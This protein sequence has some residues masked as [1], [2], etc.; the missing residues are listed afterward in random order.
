MAFMANNY[1]QDSDITNAYQNLPLND[2]THLRGQGNSNEKSQQTTKINVSGD[3]G[4]LGYTEVPP[5]TSSLLDG[6]FH[7]DSNY[8]SK[9]RWI[10]FWKWELLAGVLSICAMIAVIGLLSAIENRPLTS[11]R[12]FLQP[13]TLLS[14]LATVTNSALLFLVAEC[15]GQSKWLYFQLR[16]QRLSNYETFDRATRGPLGALGLMW[17]LKGRVMTA[18]IGAAITVGALLINPFVQQVISFPKRTVQ[19]EG[20]DFASVNVS[21]VYDTG[22]TY[23]GPGAEFFS[24]GVDP[25]DNAME[26]AIAGGL[27]SPSTS[28]MSFCSGSRCSWPTFTTLGICSSCRDVTQTT[29]INCTEDFATQCFYNTPSNFTLGSYFATQSG[30]LSRTLFNSSAVAPGYGEYLA[31]GSPGLV[32]FA[33]IKFPEY[34][35]RPVP[36]PEVLECELHLCA[37]TAANYSYNVGAFPVADAFIEF[38]LATTSDI[39]NNFTGPNNTA[40]PYGNYQVNQTN[41]KTPYTGNTNFTINLEDLAAISQF[42]VNFF[43]TGSP[44][45]T[46]TGATLANNYL[47]KSSNIPNSI[48]A[49][50]LSMTNV[51]RNGQNH[52]IVP[53]SSYNSE[54]YIRVRWEWLILPALSII[55]ANVLLVLTV[56]RNT[57]RNVPL[58]KSSSL[59]LL[60]Q[61]VDIQE[62]DGREQSIHRMKKS[63]ENVL[64]QLEEDGRRRIKV[65]QDANSLVR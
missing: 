34:T 12:F 44:A 23:V 45:A 19:Y 47:Y 55:S 3:T 43:T 46:N 22:L 21:K 16:P 58:W 33:T 50:A 7:R 29:A 38:P 42:L 62:V 36:Q 54:T 4:Y 5:H 27:S 64:V 63:A 26:G 59:P 25:I 17:M 10:L 8:K 15:I 51:I 13:N 1:H 2:T 35:A 49:M 24:Y 18:T 6:D 20:Q 57:R 53:G 52:T 56:Y 40:H 65:V 30:R 9:I 14:I 60:C 32:S 28:T 41:L 31:S 11:W 61:S 39:H 37:K 48:S